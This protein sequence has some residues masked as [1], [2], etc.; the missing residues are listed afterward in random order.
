MQLPATIGDWGEEITTVTL[1]IVITVIAVP[2]LSGSSI[3]NSARV[4]TMTLAIVAAAVSWWSAGRRLRAEHSD[5]EHRKRGQI[6]V[7][8]RGGE[9]RVRRRL[10]QQKPDQR[11]LMNHAAQTAHM[12]RHT[13]VQSVKSDGGETRIKAKARREVEAQHLGVGTKEGKSGNDK[14]RVL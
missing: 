6:A 5:R 10:V 2:A 14:S 3:G 11:E 9:V 1:D 4:F 7:P 12:R 13:H 8:A